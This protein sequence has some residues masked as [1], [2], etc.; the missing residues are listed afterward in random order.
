[1]DFLNQLM[2]GGDRQQEYRDFAERYDQGPPYE[3]ISD[4]EAADRYEE[5]A[6]HLSQEDYRLSAREAFGRMSPEERE[7]FGKMLQEQS[8]QSGG[9]IP[10]EQHASEGDLRNPDFLARMASSMHQQQP[11]ALGGL[12]KGMLGSG[13]GGLVG[14]ML[15]SGM[16]GGGGM[17][18]NPVAKAAMA[19]IAAT[20]AKKFMG[21]R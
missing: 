6:P 7:E 11:D 4:G 12:M 16:T 15:G 19:G 20:A 13:G 14:G 21:G 18:S 9:T 17:T 5:V 1:M 2:G 3:R 10:G 8:Q